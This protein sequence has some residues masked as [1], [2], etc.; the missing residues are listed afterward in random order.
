VEY[1]LNPPRLLRFV[2]PDEM[3]SPHHVAHYVEADNLVV[4]NQDLFQ[5]LD[6]T[7]KRAVER[8]TTD[9]TFD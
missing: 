6:D 5:R 2:Q 4:I 8:T 1:P 7:Q 3:P 9:L